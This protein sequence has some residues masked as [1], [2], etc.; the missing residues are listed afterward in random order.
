MQIIQ[1]PGTPTLMSGNTSLDPQLRLS[2]GPVA[3][4]CTSCGEQA[5]V[6][7]RHMVFRSLEF[8]CLGCGVPHRISNPA[9][10]GLGTRLKK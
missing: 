1:F 10:S 3:F 5:V 9:F 8:Y 2:I 7:F 6:D 4:T